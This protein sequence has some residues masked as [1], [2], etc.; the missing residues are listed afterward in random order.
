MMTVDRKRRLMVILGVVIIML[1]LAAI[2]YATSNTTP[3]L[4]RIELPPSLFSPP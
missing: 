3:K 4:D 2:I 1:S